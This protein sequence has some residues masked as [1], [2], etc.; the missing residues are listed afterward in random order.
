MS[1]N[2]GGY[3]HKRAVSSD[4]ELVETQ[5]GSHVWH[6]SSGEK[7]SDIVGKTKRTENRKL[8]R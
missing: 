3:G 2:N 4:S 6:L 5:F 1:Q 8:T 7:D